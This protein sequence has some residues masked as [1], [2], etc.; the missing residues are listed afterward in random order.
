[1]ARQPNSRQYRS[2]RSGT[3]DV[4]A[5]PSPEDAAEE[6][7]TRDRAWFDSSWELRQGLDVSE[8]Q[9]LPDGFPHQPATPSTS[10]VAPSP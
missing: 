9:E 2:Q 1:M 5:R 3:N 6:S 10:T 8:L 7:S 4:D